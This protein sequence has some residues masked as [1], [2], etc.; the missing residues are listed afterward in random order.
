MRHTCTVAESRLPWFYKECTLT[1]DLFSGDDVLGLPDHLTASVRKRS[2]ATRCQHPTPFPRVGRSH[3]PGGSHAQEP[4]LTESAIQLCT[5]DSK[6]LRR[7]PF[8]AGDF[9]H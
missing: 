7:A 4:L 8:L 2:A 9:A 6:L 3:E 1:S 5:G